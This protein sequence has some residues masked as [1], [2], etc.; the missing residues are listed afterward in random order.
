MFNEVCFYQPFYQLCDFGQI[1]IL[2]LRQF[3][4][5]RE[6]AGIK[7]NSCRPFD[8]GWHTQLVFTQL[9]L[10]KFLREKADFVL[11]ILRR[12]S[13]SL[14][15]TWALLGE[16]TVAQ[17]VPLL[18]LLRNLGCPHPKM[19]PSFKSRFRL[20]FKLTEM[21]LNIQQI[22]W[23]TGCVPGTV[24]GARDTTMA[25]QN[26][27]HGKHYMVI[28]HRRTKQGRQQGVFQSGSE[29]TL[30]R[31]ELWNQHGFGNFC[32]DLEQINPL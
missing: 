11:G 28:S 14:D 6:V 30:L 21:E 22:M 12:Q 25:K 26:M 31:C 10:Q 9:E 13:I 8:N 32:C 23:S 17:C 2:R 15:V 7:L 16:I 18:F 3:V 4:T 5:R 20:S 1:D 29:K 27:L 19:D 24:L